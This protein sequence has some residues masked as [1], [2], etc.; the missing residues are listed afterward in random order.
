[1]LRLIE[2]LEK[3]QKADNPKDVQVIDLSYSIIREYVKWQKENG[4][5]VSFLP[6]KYLTYDGKTET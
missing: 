5:E 2:L 6:E 1:M 3:Y 4:G